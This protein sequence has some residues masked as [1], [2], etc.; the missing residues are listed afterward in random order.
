[1]LHETSKIGPQIFYCYA[2]VLVAL[3]AANAALALSEISRSNSTMALSLK[4]ASIVLA[5]LPVVF[6]NRLISGFVVW[7]PS[8]RTL[9]KE[10]LLRNTPLDAL[11]VRAMNRGQLYS[12]NFYLN[13]EI[14]LVPQDELREGAVLLRSSMCERFSSD[15]WVTRELPFD[16]GRTG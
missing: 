3:A 13:K 8:G 7:D 6:A 4:G 16:T 5:L 9:A 14:P 1:A 2:A 11:S 15:R 12:L 10:L